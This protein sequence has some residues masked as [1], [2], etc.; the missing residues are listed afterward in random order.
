MEMKRE[1][2]YVYN[3]STGWHDVARGTTTKTIANV[4]S[5]FLLYIAGNYSNAIGLGS[6]LLSI[7]EAAAGGSVVNATASDYSQVN[8]KYDGVN[9]WVYGKLDGVNWYLGYY[10]QSITISQATMQQQFVVNGVGTTKT[11]YRYPGIV[12][13]PSSFDSPWAKAY[14]YL[15]NPV[16]ETV[17]YKLYSTTFYF[18]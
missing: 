3:I 2:V 10:A 4:V 14:S 8:L 9:Q 15:G 18:A 11:S 7:F 5:Q 17:S 12:C 1:R 13:K 6:T 16:S